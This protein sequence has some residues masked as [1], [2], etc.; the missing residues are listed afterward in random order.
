MRAEVAKARLTWFEHCDGRGRDHDLAAVSTG[1]DTRGA[2]HVDPDVV[3]IGDER[4]SCVDADAN[5]DEAF[6]ERVLDLGCARDSR[7]RRGEGAEERVALRVDLDAGVLAERVANDVAVASEL[8]GVPLCAELLEQP[9]RSLH[10]G[11]QERHR[12]GRQRVGH[13]SERTT[14]DPT[15]RRGGMAR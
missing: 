1:T 8:V 15:A 3:A 12:A 11:E 4:L 6:L 14:C 5:V 9:G 13:R 7:T 10:V 2:V